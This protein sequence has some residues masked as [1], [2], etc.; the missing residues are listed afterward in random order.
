MASNITFN[1][2]LASQRFNHKSRVW[3]NNLDEKGLACDIAPAAS[4]KRV[5]TKIIANLDKYGPVPVR[6][7]DLTRVRGT[8]FHLA[9][10]RKRRGFDRCARHAG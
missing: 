2:Q 10:H 6:T 8:W 5:I 7:S 4:Q 1:G 9:N 3:K